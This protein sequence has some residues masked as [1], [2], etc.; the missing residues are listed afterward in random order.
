LALVG[1]ALNDRATVARCVA[2]A[3]ADPDARRGL[4]SALGWVEPVRLK[5]IAKNLLNGSSAAQRCLGLAACRLHGVD[6]G[7]ALRT[8]LTDADNDVRAEA[9][10]TAGT[11]GLAD[12]ASPLCSRVDEDPNGQ[13]W[14]AWSAVSLGN[15]T[16]ALETLMNVGSSA[17]QHRRRA[18][19][20]AC[21]S[22]SVTAAHET[23]SHL[24]ND[25]AE[26]RWVIEGSGIVGDP[27][28]VPWLIKHMADP[29]TARL[30]GEAFSLITGVNF[31]QGGLEGKRPEG[32]E[33][34]PIDDPADPNV[35]EDPDD[36]LPWPN[37]IKVEKW[38]GANS[39]LFPKGARYFMGQPVTRE[40]C[41]QV[42][43]TG[44]Q[45]Q[46]IPAAHYL[47]L[48]NPGT[49]LF[50]TSAPAWRQQRLLAR[51]A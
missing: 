19:R 34:G 25:P 35:A 14:S 1:F 24:A 33:S 37:V 16:R 40:H 15:R 13:F 32:F 39:G 9:A 12:V 30:A 10:R 27:L 17:S 22:M 43:K 21:Q 8:A 7:T 18:F 36:S 42:L 26:I 41:I 20:L 11:L 23:L 2:L 50:N 28:Y 31:G 49:P 3:E 45:R 46:R 29:A 4:T 48:L 44:Y 6:P 38:W 51:M 47:C 5:G